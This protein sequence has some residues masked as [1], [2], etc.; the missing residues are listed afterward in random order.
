M[1]SAAFTVFSMHLGALLAIFAACSYDAVARASV[2]SRGV[3]SYVLLSMGV[4]V[5]GSGWL[6]RAAFDEH[7][8]AA[9]A[10]SWLFPGALLIAATAGVAGVRR[11]LGFPWRGPH[12]DRYL[13]AML[14]ALLVAAAAAL[15]LPLLVARNAPALASWLRVSSVLAG[16]LS[17][18]ALALCALVCHKMTQIGDRLSVW[19]TVATSLTVPSLVG[20]VSYQTS[21][22]VM[23]ASVAAA[24]CALHVAAMLCTAM[25]ALLQS[26]MRN[27]RLLASQAAV[28]FDDLGRLSVGEHMVALFAHKFAGVLQSGASP[29]VLLVNVFNH[30]AIAS[31]RGV[32]AADQVTLATLARMRTVLN[33]NDLLGRYF[34]SCFVVLIQAHV[35][36]QYLREVGLRLAASVRR[37]VALRGLSA[38]DNDNEPVLLDVGVG[39]CWSDRVAN[40]QQAMQEAGIAASAGRDH[41]SRACVVIYPDRPPLPIESVLGGAPMTEVEPPPETRPSHF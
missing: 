32:A 19:L 28:N 10:L 21:D 7:S 27:A 40:V 37:D 26:N 3:A 20:L 15:L 2:P 9:V 14:V 41:P 11:W 6:L 8:G 18:S 22:S 35:D 31:T 39:M 30:D 25:A 24:L 34:D 13:R 29:A 5:M 23:P 36:A 17:V 1:S 33:P 38:Q 4:S 16:V 12:L